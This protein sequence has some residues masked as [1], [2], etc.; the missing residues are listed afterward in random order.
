[1]ST[2]TEKTCKFSTT[3][4]SVNTEHKTA[5]EA[6]LSKEEAIAFEEKECCTALYASLLKVSQDDSYRIIRKHIS[7]LSSAL[8]AIDVMY[9]N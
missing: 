5:K 1:M 3:Y 6:G 8:A 4:E 2:Q 7:L 9:A